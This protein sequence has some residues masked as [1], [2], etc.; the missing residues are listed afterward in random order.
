MFSGLTVECFDDPDFKEDSVRELILAPLL[1]RL[2]Y[3]P[4]GST[5]VIRSKS[6]RHPFIRIGTRNH[7]VTIVPDYTL[8]HEEKPI[9]ILDAKSPKE[10]ILD[11][12][13]VQQAYSY[14]MHPEIG[15]R[16]FGL[17]NGKELAIFDVFHRDPLVVLKF[18]DFETKWSDIEKYLSV[19]YI[20]EPGRRRFAPDFGLAL[21]RMGFEHN[22]TMI[23]LGVRLNLFGR[24]KDGLY[25][26]SANTEFGDIA[27]C[28]SFDFPADMLPS[29]VSGL[30]EPLG[31]MFIDALNR[32][33]FQAAAGLVIELDIVARLGEV[34]AGH[35]EE[36]VPLLIDKITGARFNP[37]PVEND[38]KDIPDQVFQ[39]RKAFTIIDRESSY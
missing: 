27:H 14:A 21:V 11:H 29:I 1:T 6:L 9:F 17:C 31:E 5:R 2:G 35:G 22:S 7:P 24:V 37:A 12:A 30:P 18:E 10:D 8:V 26:A 36:F 4:I 38:P 20:N 3:Y 34:T 19:K 16:E 39:L 25:T 33:P 23:M 13:H 28:V 32:A 15:C